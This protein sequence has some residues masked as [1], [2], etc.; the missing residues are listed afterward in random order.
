MKHTN[1]RSALAA[2]AAFLLVAGAAWWAGSEVSALLGGPA[3]QFRHVI[4]AL[5]LLAVA[6]RCLAPA[7]SPWHSR[8]RHRGNGRD[9]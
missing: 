3:V 1:I 2:A 8:R 9:R 5:V 6:G 4:A 7:G